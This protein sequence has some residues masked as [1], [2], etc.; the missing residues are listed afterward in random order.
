MEE[1]VGAHDVSLNHV[2]LRLNNVE[3][4]ILIIK[5]KLTEFNSRIAEFSESVD[6]FEEDLNFSATRVQS[7]QNRMSVLNVTNTNLVSLFDSLKKSMIDIVKKH[8]QQEEARGALI[9]SAN[10]VKVLLSNQINALD[11]KLQIHIKDDY[12]NRRQVEETF[13][14][15]KVTMDSLEQT[16][17]TNFPFDRNSFAS[18]DGELV[19]F[20]LQFVTY[21]QISCFSRDV[22]SIY[23]RT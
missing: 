16:I 3:N 4:E 14:G 2:Q 1:K 9:K 19:V 20:R 15:F 22:P 10:D 6:S 21:N 11:Q 12:A 13:A 5:R 18:I 23:P 17:G 8:D 7:I